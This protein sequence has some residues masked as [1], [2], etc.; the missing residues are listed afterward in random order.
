M[1]GASLALGQAPG[2]NAQHQGF[3]KRLLAE[4]ASQARQHGFANLAVISA[5]GTREY[6]RARGFSDGPLYQHQRLQP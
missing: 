4:A 6:Y 1:Y 2:D 3:G 5:V